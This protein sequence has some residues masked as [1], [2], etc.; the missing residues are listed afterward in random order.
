MEAG[1]P[2]STDI[3]TVMFEGRLVKNVGPIES[4]RTALKVIL[5]WTNALGSPLGI[6]V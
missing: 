5:N 1:V 4:S 2:E 3:V 6:R